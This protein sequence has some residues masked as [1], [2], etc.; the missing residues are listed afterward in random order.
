MDFSVIVNFV[1]IGKTHSAKKNEPKVKLDK[2][3]IFIAFCTFYDISKLFLKNYQMA[4]QNIGGF[5]AF[6]PPI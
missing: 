4:C 6:G 5:E 1:V 2:I 3:N